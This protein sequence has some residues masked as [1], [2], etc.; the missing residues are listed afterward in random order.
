LAQAGRSNGFLFSAVG[1]GT[2]KSQDRERRGKSE[3]LLSEGV[4]YWPWPSIGT[5]EAAYSNQRDAIENI[6]D[7]D[8][9]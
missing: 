6:I 9:K 2:R 3:P 7:A 5:F 1:P 4:N 8:A